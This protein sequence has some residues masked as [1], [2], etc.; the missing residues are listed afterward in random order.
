MKDEAYIDALSKAGADIVAEM[1]RVLKDQGHYLTGALDASFGYRIVKKASGEFEIEV[2]ALSYAKALQTG[3]KPEDVNYTLTQIIQYFRRRGLNVKEAISAGIATQ[4]V[5]KRVGIP[6]KA[7]A[8]F[9]KTGRRTGF[10]TEAY[11][12]VRT[13]VNDELEDGLNK[14]FRV[15][16]ADDFLNLEIVVSI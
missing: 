14:A 12:N 2:Y 5:H 4:K 11:K 15:E 3:V 16:V 10:I 9:S 7:S 13:R 1:R 6:T 8:R